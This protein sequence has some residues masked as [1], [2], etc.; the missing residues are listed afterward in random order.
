M[1]LQG[2]NAFQFFV[3]FFLLTVSK[4]ATG[5][6]RKIMRAWGVCVCVW[7]LKFVTM[8]HEGKK[9]VC[10]AWD[11]HPRRRHIGMWGVGHEILP[12]KP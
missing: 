11:W 10:P 9:S 5:I 4:K 6:I 12:R 1:Y 7:C 2:K 8:T 3:F